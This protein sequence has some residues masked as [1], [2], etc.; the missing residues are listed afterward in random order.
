MRTNVEPVNIEVNWDKTLEL[1]SKTNRI[2]IINYVNSAF[3]NVSGYEE[4]ELLGQPH[5]IIRHPDMPKA[6]FR[7]LWENLKQG[8]DFHAIIKN[9]AKD[10][11]YYWI[12]TQYDFFKDTEGDIN[13]YMARRKAVTPEVIS[14]IEGVYKKIKNIEDT[15]GLDASMA[16][17]AGFLD[18][19]KQTYDEFLTSILK[20]SDKKEEKKATEKKSFWNSLFS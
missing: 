16:Y 14:K 17:F 20:S 7:M 19:Q 3:V 10:G 11:K 6:I 4:S 2:G 8:K 9:K 5:N 12:I 18:E 15:K 1:V 13:G